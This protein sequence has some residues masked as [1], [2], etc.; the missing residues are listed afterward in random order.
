MQFSNYLQLEQRQS[1]VFEDSGQGLH[2]LF[3]LVTENGVRIPETFH[4]AVETFQ[5]VFEKLKSN[6]E[7]IHKFDKLNRISKSSSNTS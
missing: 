6:S 4:D 5:G 2:H 3:D 7:E 1:G